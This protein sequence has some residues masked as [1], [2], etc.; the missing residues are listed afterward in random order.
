FYKKHRALLQYGRFFRISEG[1]DSKDKEDANRVKWV[2]ANADYSEMLVLD[3]QILNQSNISQE[4]LRIPFAKPEFDY[5]IETREQKV[6]VSQ[7]GS[8]IN[9]ISPVHISQEGSVKKLIDKNVMLKNE[10]EYHIVSGDV[11]AYSGV[12]LSPQFSGTGFS[13]NTRVLGDFG[14]RL[15][16]IVRIQKEVRK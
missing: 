4:I 1:V 8:L 2:V 3:F 5:V 13:S 15:Y 11:L 12:R 10:D 16:H 6:P 7:F 14:S 9:M